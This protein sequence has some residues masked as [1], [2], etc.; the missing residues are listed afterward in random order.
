MNHG[1]LAKESFFVG[2]FPAFGN[3]LGNLVRGCPNCMC[4][5]PKCSCNVK[6]PDFTAI[7]PRCTCE[8]ALTVVAVGIIVFISLLSGFVVVNL[9]GGRFGE[10]NVNTFSE[11]SLRC[12][13]EDDLT[14][15]ILRPSGKSS[16]SLGASS[17]ASLEAV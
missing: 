4:P 11:S 14:S 9:V 16:F 12:V 3:L 2:V 17:P 6:C 10:I 1:V 15:L 13:A 8:S 7:E 5:T